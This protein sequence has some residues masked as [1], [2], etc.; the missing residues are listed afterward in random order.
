MQIEL[1]TFLTF[2]FYIGLLLTVVSVLMFLTN[3]TLKRRLKGKI[4]KYE[5]YKESVIELGQRRD[6]K[7]KEQ[8][9]EIKHLEQRIKDLG[10]K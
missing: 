7:I 4:E 6:A 10:G 8:A 3:D 2:S 1:I 5:R 9:E